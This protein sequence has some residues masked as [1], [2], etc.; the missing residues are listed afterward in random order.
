MGPTCDF[1]ERE[2]LTQRP[3]KP[4]S[5]GTV[6]PYWAAQ[7]GRWGSFPL[8]LIPTPVL[9]AGMGFPMGNS[10]EEQHLPKIPCQ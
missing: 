4:F 10:I 8:L 1:G 3:A 5:A 7:A 6:I 2:S 9:I